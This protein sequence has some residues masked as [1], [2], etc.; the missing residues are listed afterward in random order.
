MS[1]PEPSGLLPGFLG[2]SARYAAPVVVIA[3]I[4]FV[5]VP[6]DLESLD[7]HRI[8]HHCQDMANLMAAIVASACEG[9][10]SATANDLI[11]RYAP[12]VEAL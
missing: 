5:Y 11:A 6:G 12:G 1:A 9:K 8:A 10:D 4:A 2:L 3:A 7:E